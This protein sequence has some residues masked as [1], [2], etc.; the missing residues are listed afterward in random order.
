MSL[1]FLC[2]LDMARGQISTPRPTDLLDTLTIA[3]LVKKFYGIYGTKKFITLLT[4]VRY[5][6][7]NLARIIQSKWQLLISL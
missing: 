5:G 7:Y 6:P 2:P 1:P 4:T 3:H